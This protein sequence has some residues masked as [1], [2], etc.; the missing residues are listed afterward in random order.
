MFNEIVYWLFTDLL[1]LSL[2]FNKM[3]VLCSLE[4]TAFIFIDPLPIFYSAYKLSNMYKYYMHKYISINIYIYINTILIYNHR[5]HIFYF[6]FF[7]VNQPGPQRISTTHEMYLLY[8]MFRVVFPNDFVSSRAK[9]IKQKPVGG[10]FC[11][12]ITYNAKKYP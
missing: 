12:D 2:Q 6:L 10:V 11:Q 9:Q 7:H 8:I 4:I 3:L 1:K 5:T